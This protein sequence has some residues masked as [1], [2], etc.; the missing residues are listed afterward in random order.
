M[1]RA[2]TYLNSA[3]TRITRGKTLLPAASVI[4]M[5]FEEM[6]LEMKQDPFLLN[7]CVRV[8]ADQQNQHPL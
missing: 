5:S 3:D 6:S 4:F 2:S 7:S 1:K 8:T